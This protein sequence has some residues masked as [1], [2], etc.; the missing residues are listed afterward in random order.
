MF[1]FAGVALHLSVLVATG[2]VSAID[3]QEMEDPSWRYRQSRSGQCASHY[4][5]ISVCPYVWLKEQCP[6]PIAHSQC[7]RRRYH[8][9]SRRSA[10]LR[11]HSTGMGFAAVKSLG[12]MDGSWA[13]G[14]FPTE[15]H[16]FGAY[17]CYR[18][19]TAKYW[20]TLDSRARTIVI[21]R[22]PGS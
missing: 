10:G 20:Q 13:A 2:R 4:H 19:A 1:P 8:P 17:T 9:G 16:L 22:R 7:E 11:T 14:T 21:M 12:D 5:R 18:S 6:P 15:Y 3:V